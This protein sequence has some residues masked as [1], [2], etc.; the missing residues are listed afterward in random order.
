[1]LSQQPLPQSSSQSAGGTFKAGLFP[2]LALQSDRAAQLLNQA[3][4]GLDQFAPSNW[5]VGARQSHGLPPFD[6]RPPM[7]LLYGNIMPGVDGGGGS[8]GVRPPI[9]PLYGAPIV[10]GGGGGGGVRPPIM[11]LYGAPIIPGGGG[12]GQTRP[13]IMML[14]GLVPPPNLGSI[15]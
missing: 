13:P 7:Q 1:M 14:Y 11:P 15:S 2:R 12:G 4:Q 9:M 10:P 5:R 8:G 3:R 6:Q